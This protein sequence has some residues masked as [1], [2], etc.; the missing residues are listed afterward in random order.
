MR[1]ACLLI[2]AAPEAVAGYEAALGLPVARIYRGGYSG[3]YGPPSGLAA[4][5]TLD[6]A[7][8]KYAPEAP[9]SAP[10]V[11][12]G[13]SAGCWSIRHWLLDPGNRTRIVAA[14]MV[15]G[16]HASGSDLRA[17]LSSA[18]DGVVAYA[19]EAM[20]GRR[21]L[22]ITHSQIVPPGYAS[23]RTTA[24]ALLERLGVPRP[25]AYE[26]A[27]HAGLHVIS[28]VGGDGP[29]HSAQLMAVGP[30]VC[31]EHV[32]PALAAL[33]ADTDPAPPVNP[34]EPLQRRALDW[35]LQEADDWG[36]RQVAEQRV[37][38]YSAG[39]VRR[40]KLLQIFAKN[41]CAA[42]QG[43]AESQVALPG[44]P[45]PPWRAGAREAMHDAEAGLRGAWH[46]IEEV[47]ATGYLPPPGSLPVYWRGSPADWRGHIER[48]I[49]SRPGEF[50][51]VGAN[52]D[53]STKPGFQPGWTI[54]TSSITH[55]RLLGFV[56]DE[57]P[58]PATP[59]P[60]VEPPDD[61]EEQ[62]LT[63]QERARLWGLVALTLEQAEPERWE[64]NG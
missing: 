36:D 61:F 40:G 12:V 24:S 1:P 62:P 60:L 42:A 9:P 6:R 32:A 45:R 5:L 41:F 49:E 28:G 59:Q 8:E 46:S 50:D 22:V 4:E 21:A 31:S 25:S 19:K 15:D 2:H 13:F 52:E 64:S 3:S 17:V 47:R 44:E 53:A 30:Q 34:A 48:V 29:A 23:T 11:L 35:C 20:A 37:A 63:E 26:S 56:V 18:H 7:L 51:A 14:V 10:V 39:C 57:E 38:E 58:A 27:H 54:Q 55:E 43:F 16:Y 33:I